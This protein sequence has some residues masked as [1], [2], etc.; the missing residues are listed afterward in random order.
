MFITNYADFRNIFS[1]HGG[2]YVDPPALDGHRA[3]PLDKVVSVTSPGTGLIQPISSWI[4]T[5]PLTIQQTNA[6]D[7]TLFVDEWNWFVSEPGLSAGE[8][9]FYLTR[10][11]NLP[12]S[13]R[14][15]RCQ[16][17]RTVAGEAAMAGPDG[18]PLHSAEKIDKI[19]RNVYIYT[20]RISGGEIYIADM[21][22]CAF[23]SN[24]LTL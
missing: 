17:N 10:L 7:G 8:P 4:F 22:R 12:A 19:F 5:W 14:S 1:L 11:D 18:A 2:T 16:L 24:T 15:G 23:A 21:H 20:Q 9:R 6:P 3:W 13:T